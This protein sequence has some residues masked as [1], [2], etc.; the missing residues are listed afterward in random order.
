MCGTCI[1]NPPQRTQRD[2]EIDNS[3]RGRMSS[4]KF[5]MNYDIN[6]DPHTNEYELKVQGTN[7]IPD[8]VNARH[9]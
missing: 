3:F 5:G 1:V 7:N 8:L 4:E 6:V 9:V 2:V